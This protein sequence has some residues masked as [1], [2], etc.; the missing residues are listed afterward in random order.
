MNTELI[1]RKYGPFIYE[2][3]TEKMREYAL[4]ISGGVP[5]TGFLAADP[6]ADM[7][8]WL[9]EL[10]AGAKSPYGS[11]VALPSFAVVFSIAPFGKAVA[12]P[13]L[14]ID[15][16]R[17]VHGE[18][19]FEWFAPI[20]PGDVMRTTGVITELYSKANK[21]FVILVSETHNQREELVVKGTW[22]AVI[23]AA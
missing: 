21:D 8:P 3:G 18:Q 6:P 23:R 2:V 7:H 12:D 1:G 4:T 22:T 9:F 17:L 5:S 14:G 10:E 11:I 13:A 15:L 19:D 16:M 20:K